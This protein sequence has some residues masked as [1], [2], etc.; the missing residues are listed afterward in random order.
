MRK[1][2]TNS[3][4]P[5]LGA[6]EHGIVQKWGDGIDSLGVAR[7]RTRGKQARE[8]VRPMPPAQRLATV[9]HC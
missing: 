1:R 8:A 7:S 3:A 9:T 2:P 5:T 6:V 4:A